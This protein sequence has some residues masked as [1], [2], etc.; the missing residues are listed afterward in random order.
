[1]TKRIIKALSIIILLAYLLIP[2]LI[3]FVFSLVTKWTFTIIP[4]GFTFSWYQQLFADNSFILALSRTVILS[5][6]ATFLSVIIIVP[7]SF[8]VY[9]FFPKLDKIMNI[10]IIGVFSVPGII[11]VMSLI[12]A[13]DGIDI[14]RLILVVGYY[15]LGS[16]P[17]M[18]IGI[19]NSL[20]SI[21]AIEMIESAEILGAS[22]LQTFLQIIVPNIRKTII[23]VALFRF[24][25]LFGE[26]G[27]IN[28]LVGGRFE[29]V[30]IFLRKQIMA[31]GHFTSAIIM[32]YFII[33]TLFTT[34]G[35]FI[36][37]DRKEAANELFIN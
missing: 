35:L 2:I 7:V 31:S 3:T 33:V 27:V 17:L 21:N 16:V 32:T 13:Y 37:R 5:F 36:V 10:I 29:T 1:M 9:I 11:A 14:P 8:S 15:V 26:Y 28:L 20:K 25:T 18:H 34:L 12:S 24:S 22:K 19:T 23:A 30:Q 6:I 4:E